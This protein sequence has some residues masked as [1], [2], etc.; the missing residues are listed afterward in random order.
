MGRAKQ[1]T[2]LYN[3]ELASG[4]TQMDSTGDLQVPSKGQIFT[5]NGG[6]WKVE[7]VTVDRVIAGMKLLNS[8]NV[9][10]VEA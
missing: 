10:L 3:A 9:Y 8:H 4:E 7:A 5:R 6:R 1:I 2:Y